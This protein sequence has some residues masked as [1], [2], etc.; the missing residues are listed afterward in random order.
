AR[1]PHA[2]NATSRL[3]PTCADKPGH[4]ELRDHATTYSMTSL[5]GLIRERERIFVHDTCVSPV[6]NQL[7]NRPTV[8]PLIRPRATSRRKWR[9]TG[10][11]FT[12][13]S[14]CCFL[15]HIFIEQNLGVIRLA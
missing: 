15:Q 14:A 10:N 1:V 12:A 7:T 8:A 2:S 5:L 6:W 11:K 4:D 13:M 9:K 3:N